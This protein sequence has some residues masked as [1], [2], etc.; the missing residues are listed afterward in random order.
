MIYLPKDLLTGTYKQPRLF[1]CQTNKER[2]GELS[3]TNLNGIFKWNAYHEVSFTIDRAYTDNITGE[4]K[5]N[6]YFDFAEAL[7]LIEVEGFGYFQIQDPNNELDGI[8]D[9]KKIT[10]YSA[11]YALS[12]RYLELF[13]INEG[14][15]G[16]IDDVQLYNPLDPS[17]SLLDLALR[18]KFPD[19]KIGHVDAELMTEKRFFNVDRQSVYDFLMNEVCN[20]FKCV[21]IFDTINNT[22]NVYTED[23]AGIETDAIITFDNLASKMSVTYSADD[24][25]TVLYV[26]GKDDL[27]IRTINFGLPYIVDLSY[28]HTVDWMGQDLFDAYQKYLDKMSSLQATHEQL[29]KKITDYNANILE[30]TNRQS[31]MLINDVLNLFYSPF[32]CDFYDE[33]RDINNNIIKAKYTVTKE[34]MDEMLESLRYKETTVEETGGIIETGIKHITNSEWD[35]FRA[36]LENTSNSNDVKDQAI[37]T[38]LK[39]ILGDYDNDSETKVGYGSSELKAGY[40]SRA[41]TNATQATAGWSEEDHH[42]YNFYYANYVLMKAVEAELDV[43]KAEILEQEELLSAANREINLLASST[44]MDANFTPGQLTRLSPFLRE[45]EYSDDCFVVTDVDIEEDVIATKKALKETASKELKK[46]C[47]PKLSFSA[48]IANLFAMPEFEPIRSQFQLGN[49]IKVRLRDGYLKKTRLMEVALDFENMQSLTSKFGDMLST[50]SQ[51]DIHADLLSQALTA[52][53]NV[54]DNSSYWQAGANSATEIQT[55]ITQG[56]LDAATEIKSIDGTQSAVIDKYGIHLRTVNE[57]GSIDPKQGWIVSNKFLYTDN[58]WK[59]TKSVFGEFKYDVNGD[60]VAES[61]YGILADALIGGYIEGSKI[62]GGT[63][64]IGNGTFKVSED[65]TVSMFGGSIGNTSVEDIDK[66]TSSNM[67]RIEVRANGSTVLTKHGQT[68]T[69]TCV[70]YSW[71]N[72]ITSTLD[73]GLFTWKRNSSDPDQDALWNAEEHHKGVKSITISTEDIKGSASFSCEVDLP[74]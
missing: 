12:Q 36:T 19:W 38:M 35:S 53:K 66:F 55:K 58:N 14:T 63:I 9:T 69:L 18:E 20:T 67:Y 71:D 74:D 65:G 41:G 25:K 68:T 72:D 51:P 5:V 47:Q 54:A 43:R 42:D 46:L 8:Q 57:D 60:G 28:Y 45:D 49:M 23:E 16:S 59:S 50:R 64:N 10:A 40:D 61:L 22:L 13:I 21:I 6:P 33:K 32:L 26:K 2:I 52:G 1:L 62:V 7:R 3:V 44:T 39:K 70:V 29:L 27:E 56:L 34:Y 24:I 37:N 15:T 11:E 30:L 73:P 48:T 4:Q 31:S 17:K